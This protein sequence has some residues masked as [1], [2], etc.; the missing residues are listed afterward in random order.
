M[1]N[2]QREHCEDRDNHN[3]EGD[4]TQSQQLS[5][6]EKKGYCPLKLWHRL[7]KH[8][9]ILAILLCA[10]TYALENVLFRAVENDMHSTEVLFSTHLVK[11]LFLIPIITYKGHSLRQASKVTYVFLIGRGVI[12]MIAV[13]TM[14]F[15]VS[16]INVGDATAIALSSPVFI[17]IFAKIFLKESFG[18]IDAL[19]TLVVVAGVFLMAKPPFIFGGSEEE[20]I[21]NLLGVAFASFSCICNALANV[22]CRHLGLLHINS[23][24][25]VLYF[26]TVCFLGSGIL[27]SIFGVWSVPPCSYARI[28]LVT[29]G[30]VG[31]VGNSSKAYAYSKEKSVFL[32]IFQTNEIIF[33]YLLEFLLFNA[34]PDLIA[35]LGVCLVVSASLMTLIKKRKE[36]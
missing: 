12:S 9:G 5:S 19:L 10:F 21:S 31:C 22:L 30:I 16:Y 24:V 8:I 18:I 4:E 15:A 35:L 34:I 29:M 14:Y 20:A 3:G 6:T 36:V 25:N 32:G 27:T 28:I 11:V 33:A 17:G 23:F 1:V 7:H 26:V 2:E 13:N